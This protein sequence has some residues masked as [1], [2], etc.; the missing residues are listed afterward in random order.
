MANTKVY[1]NGLGLSLWFALP[2]YAA[3][4]KNPT[5]AEINASKNITNS[6]SW[7]DYSFG[8]QASNQNS[9]P[10]LGD[11]GNVQTR[12]FAQFGGSISFY[13][14]RN[15]TDVANE[16]LT[17]FLALEQQGTVGY[18]IIRADGKKTTASAD[19]KNKVAVTGDWVSIYKVES[20]GWKDAVTGE[21]GYRYTITFL[22]Q[23]DLWVNA[24]V[25]TFTVT[26]P[27]PIGTPDYVSPT[28]KTPLSTY[29]SGREL[30][31]TTGEWDGYP[32]FFSW[33]SSDPTKATVDANGVVHAVAAGTADIVATDKITGTASTALSVTIT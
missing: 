12:G 29:R 27:A 22:P 26:T 18:I 28:G 33:S 23:G 15:Y 8:T 10:A 21:Q 16:Y 32:G 25:G 31:K 2:N 19:D 3:D 6:T 1:A 17:T 11:V 7:Q 13:Y 30:A 9:D 14:P 20:D 4:P 24:Q 5:A